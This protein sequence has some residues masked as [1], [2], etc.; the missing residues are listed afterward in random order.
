MFNHVRTL[1][2]NR[3]GRS[4]PGP[5]FPGEEPVPA[6]YRVV[7]LPP[8][9]TAARSVLFGQDPDRVY[10]NYR[11]QEYMTLLHATE[12]VEHVL[13]FDPR[14]TYE[15]AAPFPAA[16]FGTTTEGSERILQVVGLPAADEALGRLRTQ[17]RVSVEAGGQ[18]T[19][20]RETPPIA[21]GYYDLAETPLLPL[22]GPLKCLPDPTAGSVWA[23]TATARPTRTLPDIVA[24]LRQTV[25]EVREVQ[26]F[27]ANPVEPYLTYRNL[28]AKH[29]ALP[30]ALGGLLL[31]VARRTHEASG[32]ENA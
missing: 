2:L 32:R 24:A 19:V 29:P 27:G 9:V 18:A 26:L 6:A 30:Y 25:T 11:L 16:A 14:V 5:D 4:G 21:I 17:W 1:L 13:A 15:T 23:V 7:L 20:S 3:D 12:L 31:A 8:A 10:L 28:W 22:A